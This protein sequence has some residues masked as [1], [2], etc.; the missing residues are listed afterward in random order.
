M[1]DVDDNLQ[2]IDRLPASSLTEEVILDKIAKGYLLNE[3]TPDIIKNNSEYIYEYLYRN[4]HGKYTMVSVLQF[5]N[6]LCFDDKTIHSIVYSLNNSSYLQFVKIYSKKLLYDFVEFYDSRFNL[7]EVIDSVDESILDEE[8]I[9]FLIKHCSLILAGSS[10]E[11][12]I[13][14]PKYIKLFLQYGGS[15]EIIDFCSSN[16]LTYEIL[17][18]AVKNG[19]R[20][21]R[22]SSSNLKSDSRLIKLLVEIGDIRQMKLSIPLVEESILTNQLI[23][24]AINRGYGSDAY[25]LPGIILNN[26][27]FL[28][29]IIEKHGSVWNVDNCAESILD[30]KLLE[31][32][33][34]KGYVYN[35]RT[36]DFVKNNRYLLEYAL[37]NVDSIEED[38]TQNA[39][40]KFIDY[41]NPNIL[42]DTLI[43]LAIKKG[44]SISNLTPK[45]IS[46][47]REYV[48]RIIENTDDPNV[49]Y[50]IPLDILTVD[51][52]YQI[53]KRNSI[54]L[55][56]YFYRVEL[57]QN[58][59]KLFKEEYESTINEMKDK[60]K[61]DKL[62][63]KFGYTIALIYHDHFI[64]SDKF[65]KTLGFEN[66]CRLFKYTILSK[67]SINIESILKNNIDNLVYAYTFIINK[68]INNLDMVL[69]LKFI[70]FYYR[71]G[72]VINTL[73]RNHK[74][75][76]YRSNLLRL[77]DNIFAFEITSVKGLSNINQM[78][79]EENRKF[80]LKRE[81]SN[82][83]QR[84]RC[85]IL[86]EDF[87]ER[88]C[89]LLTDHTLQAT[90]TFLSE[91]MNSYKAKK[92]Y[93]QLKDSSIKRLLQNYA[94]L[95][96]FLEFVIN[97]NDVL[98]L[99]RILEILND[100]SVNNPDKINI[101][102]DNFKYIEKNIKSIYGYEA[103]S[104][105]T[106]LSQLKNGSNVKI[107][108]NKYTSHNTVAGESLI[109]RTVD[110]IELNDEAYFFTHAMNF[111]GKDGKISDF[112]HPRLIGKAYICLSAISSLHKLDKDL[113]TINSVNDVILLFDSID[114]ECL[115]SM[116]NDDIFSNSNDNSLD[117]ST[118]ENNFDTL[119]ATI[120][121][122]NSYNEYVFYRE[123]NS[124][125]HIYPSAVLVLASEPTQYEI[126]AACYLNV[127]LVKMNYVDSNTNKSETSEEKDIFY[128]YIY[129]KDLDMLETALNE[130]LESVSSNKYKKIL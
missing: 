47:N 50:F 97:N 29:Q 86:G 5:A 94:N 118:N 126:D 96:D 20:L 3:N 87:K 34:S 51:D 116:G 16:V 60:E 123:N 100:Y 35:H 103:N 71:F 21:K 91:I 120:E 129:S 101:L 56:R 11:L 52:I 62:K 65:I 30:T 109:G 49:L 40:C 102:I 42:D 106:K 115:V 107:S 92:M 111:C 75:G 95:F 80:L 63:N 110:Y 130:V 58:A 117:I 1:N 61:I 83:F 68:D 85:D 27:D 48:I 74:I 119:K 24:I 28:Y 17:Y 89:L 90:N 39:V 19:Y 84:I 69:F 7:N 76:E 93:L 112:K 53:I 4:R 77:I 45:I 12:I 66:A 25:P 70:N 22:S 78:I 73:I 59:E 72:N 38:S 6:Q 67:W 37:N 13:N 124:G 36:K 32:A 41:C 64:F 9:T 43:D 18:S 81:D 10:P 44:Y 8:T 82:S 113:Y 104:S 127:P 14:S 26:Y 33:I 88:I 125:K 114:P 31:L 54:F 108:K 98:E 121:N 46:N 15:T 2:A 99:K 55:T 79:F 57:L 122:T 23:N 128:D 105:L